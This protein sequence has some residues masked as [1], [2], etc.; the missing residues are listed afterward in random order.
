VLRDDGGGRDL[1][2]VRS[3]VRRDGKVVAVYYYH[4][5]SGP[6]R[7]LAATIWDPGTP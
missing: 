2:Y 3:V 6:T 5:R 4:D 7:Y 1:G